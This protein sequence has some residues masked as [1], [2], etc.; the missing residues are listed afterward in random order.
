MSNTQVSLFRRMGNSYNTGFLD[1]PFSSFYL[2]LVMLWEMGP[3]LCAY[4]PLNP[5]VHMSTGLALI[6]GAAS[7]HYMVPQ[8]LYF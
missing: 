3:A 7:M 8:N 5:V 4:R 2:H 1:M 6:Y